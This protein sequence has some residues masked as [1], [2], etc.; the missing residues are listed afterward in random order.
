MRQDPGRNGDGARHPR[1]LIV[2]L[3]EAC[4]AGCFMC[5]FARS[6]DGYRFG[7]EET[8]RLLVELATTKIRLIRFTGGEPL[9]VGELPAMLSAIREAGIGTSVITNGW[10]LPERA[11]A[12]AQAGLDQV[13]VSLDGPCAETHDRY[14]QLPGLFER[15]VDGVQQVRAARTVRVRCNTVVGPHNL[16]HMPAI[17]KLLC[18]LG[19][20]QWSLIPMK[21][22]DGTWAAHSREHQEEELAALGEEVRRSRR[23]DPRRGPAILGPGL[24]FL[25]RS[26][27]ERDDLWVDGRNMTPRGTCRLVDEVRY[28]TPS[29]G[30]VFPCNCVPHRS[31]DRPLWEPYDRRSF[32]GGGLREV[33]DWLRQE[34][35]SRCTGCEPANVALGEGRIDLDEDPFGY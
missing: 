8:R 26:P 7:L 23:R 24:H 3:L 18:D 25:G 9:Y 32:T 16:H 27:E 31:G 33:R 15:L 2:R 22:S 34:G 14:R 1:V 20:E 11:R 6:T 29:D 4:N 19:V 13:I 12:L 21:R 28:Y 30:A 10:F 17:W 5:G 35:P